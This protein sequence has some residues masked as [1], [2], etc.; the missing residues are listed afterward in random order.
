M[1]CVRIATAA[2]SRAVFDLCVGFAT[3]FRPEYEVFARTFPTL[4]DSPD[5]HLLVADADDRLV[6]YLLGFSHPT[7]FANGPISTVEELTVDATYRHR[8]VARALMAVFES[9][10][11]ERGCRY[12]A[13]DTR[14]AEGFYEA[15]GYEASATFYRKMLNP[16]GAWSEAK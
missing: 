12:V 14:R 16:T 7:L 8:G 13:V 4:L 3:S 11:A 6:G 2:D 9:W 15:L 1:N 5:A 10:S